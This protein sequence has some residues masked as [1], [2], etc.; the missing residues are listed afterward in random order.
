MFDAFTHLFFD[1][2]PVCRACVT[3]RWRDFDDRS[4]RG[5]ALVLPA[6]Y[7]RDAIRRG[8]NRGLSQLDGFPG[9][10]TKKWQ[11]L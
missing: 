1:V 6:T 4:R 11:N 8:G 10:M 2:I 7:K 3:S 5:D 9:H